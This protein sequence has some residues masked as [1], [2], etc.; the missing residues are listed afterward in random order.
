MGLNYVGILIVL[1][2]IYV[3][4]RYFKFCVYKIDMKKYKNYNI[5]DF[6]RIYLESKVNVPKMAKDTF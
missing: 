1:E 5:I 3:A 2:I 4:I 6:I